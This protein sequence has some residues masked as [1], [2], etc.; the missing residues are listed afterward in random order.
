MQPID[1]LQRYWGYNSFRECQAE[2]ID[3][4]LSGC[5]TIGLLPT[6]G[7]KSITF[8]VPA[9][10]ISGMTLVI[11]PLISLMKDQVDNLR[12]RHIAAGCL[13]SGLTQRETRLTLDRIA[14]GKTKVLYLAPER[15]SRPEF[16][17]EIRSWD[18]GLIVV[19]EAHCISQWG[20][21]FR[22]SYL[23]ISS[24]RRIFPHVPVMALTASATPAV[25]DDIA[26]KLELRAP[27]IFRRS[28]ARPNISYIVRRCDDKNAMLL[29]VLQNTRGSA[30]VYV[31][32]R[33]RTAEIAEML[34][35]HG[36]SADF[37]HAGL[38]SEE[39]NSRQDNWKQ[40]TV[41]VIVATNA[42]GMGIDKP[43]VRTVVHYDLPPSLEEYYQ[44]AGR[45]GRDGQESFAVM[46]TTSSDK[47]LLKRR[48][49]ESFPDREFQLLVYEKLGNFLDVAVGGG[50]NQVFE[51]DFNVFCRTFRLPPRPT[52]AALSILT[53][54]GCIEYCDD[55]NSR[56]RLMVTIDKREF[57][58][59]RLDSHS[60]KVLQALLR[61]YTGLFA[62]YVPIDEVHIAYSTS[63]SANDVY[64][65][66]L[67]LSRMHVVS[68]IPKR[69]KPYVYYPTSRDLPKHVVV[70]RSVYEDQFERADARMEAMRNY[71]FDDCDCR[72]Q[73]M[74]SYFGEA[75]STPCG[76][77]DL[78]RAQQR[79]A[80]KTQR[81]ATI[82]ATLDRLIELSPDGFTTATL[83]Q[84]FPRNFDEAIALL[85]RRIDNGDLSL[86][87]DTFHT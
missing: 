66:L 4:A 46:L 48:L 52:A 50:Y 2:I 45:A 42:F 65:S 36:I 77:C 23:N 40:G 83:R 73:R 64:Q 19:D 20:Y 69:N 13:H 10:I 59:L 22:P 87:D 43:D 18:V 86:T 14:L 30:I 39:K 27:A 41:R 53:R 68:Y 25:V 60:D 9:M 82:E 16:L 33:R 26:D 1:V 15:L 74:L 67:L 44:E 61:N 81:Y 72:V 54:A 6:G 76:K 29:R 84:A 70:P 38:D 62:D 35:A 51:C 55:I 37:Y 8:Q 28:F 63:I 17:A 56:S 57:Y 24:L 58:S 71:A 34:K 85:R 32:S 75:A 5:D 47:A 78:C 11:S 79:N 12:E 7:G 3:S 21:D 80:N 31:R 49:T